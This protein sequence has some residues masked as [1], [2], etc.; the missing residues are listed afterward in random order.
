MPNFALLPDED[1]DALTDYVIYLSVRGETERDLLRQVAYMLDYSRG[2][3][4]FDENWRES[5]PGRYDTQ[6]R[7]LSKIAATYL[8][9]WRV[10]AQPSPVRPE[11]FP[12]WEGPYA[13]DTVI[14]PP[15]L[16][17]IAR[18]KEA[19]NSSVASCAKCHGADGTGRTAPRDYDLWTKDW[20]LAAGIDPQDKD[21][22]RPMLKAGALKP[23]QLYPRNLNLGIFRGGNRPEDIYTRIV[24]G[25]EGTSMPAAALQSPAN[26]G[27]TPD[28][29]W[30]LVNYVLSLADMQSTG[31]QGASTL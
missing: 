5:D 2:D 11:G 27:L 22:I 8:G 31:R 7:E 28:Q 30:D 25:I 9:Q 20:T 3:R 1:I 10:D 23:V 14:E 18:G 19:F 4:I 13:K 29:V 6:L 16:E 21:A 24:H 17:S 12:V 15:L 26:Q